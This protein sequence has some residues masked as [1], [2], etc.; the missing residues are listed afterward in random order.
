[1]G[2]MMLFL[3]VNAFLLNSIGADKYRGAFVM[4]A[5]SVWATVICLVFL[6]LVS[7]FQRRSDP[8]VGGL[9]GVILFGAVNAVFMV[10]FVIFVFAASAFKLPDQPARIL[11]Q[12]ASALVFVALPLAALGWAFLRQPKKEELQPAHDPTR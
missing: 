10:L 1:M 7:A 4:I 5:F 2:I 6:G 12:I 3:V 9:L 8:I 11:L